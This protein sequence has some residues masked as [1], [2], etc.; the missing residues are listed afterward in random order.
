MDTA[1]LGRSHAPVKSRR[2]SSVGDGRHGDSR[3]DQSGRQ[4]QRESARRRLRAKPTGRTSPI[5][6]SLSLSCIPGGCGR[7]VRE[8]VAGVIPGGGCSRPPFAC[9]VFSQPHAPELARSVAPASLRSRSPFGPPSAGPDGPPRD[10][11]SVRRVLAA[12]FAI[13]LFIHPQYDL[14]HQTHTLRTG[15]RCPSRPKSSHVQVEVRRA[16]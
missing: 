16:P 4:L 10:L 14:Q 15:C 13:A 1:Q 12:R 8:L 3:S 11:R 5:H 6:P 2:W 7:R 9:C